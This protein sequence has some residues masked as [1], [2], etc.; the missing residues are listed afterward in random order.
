VGVTS[1]LAMTYVTLGEYEKLTGKTIEEFNEAPMLRTMVAAGELPP[2]EERLP[3]DPFVVV[4]IDR[5]GIYGGTA[6]V[7]TNFTTAPVGS[8]WGVGWGHYVRSNITAAKVELNF[9]KRVEVSKDKTTFTIYLRR[10]VKWSDGVPFTADD[11]MFWYTDV[12]H[13]KELTPVIGG[14]WE[15]VKVQKLDDYT[16][17]IKTPGPRPYFLEY[18]I[19]KGRPNGSYNIPKHYLKQFHPKYTAEEEL[20]KRVEEAGFDY[21]YE[22]F[23]K[24]NTRYH[25]LPV[26]T[27]CPTLASYVPVKITSSQRVFE[28]N[29]YYWK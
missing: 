23:W 20:K 2:V 16:I 27:E 4:P 7:A 29:P 6:H 12:L 21:W 17:Q 19:S 3:E 18:P 14:H 15:G 28:R 8:L 9:A 1:A 10:G 22:L 26:D 13:N 5:I 11:P 25:Q 24:K